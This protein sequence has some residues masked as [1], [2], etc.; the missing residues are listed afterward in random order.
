M[1]DNNKKTIIL[2]V[3]YTSILLASMIGATFAYFTS[4]V[5]GA[6]SKVELKSSVLSDAYAN[7][8]SVNL[9]VSLIDMQKN[10]SSNDY[11]SY[12]DSQQPGTLTLNSTVGDKLPKVTCTYDILY[13]PTTVYHSSIENNSNLKEFVINGY[14]EVTNGGSNVSFVGSM[15]ETD[16]TNVSDT[17]ILVHNAKLIIN[18][19]NNSGEITWNFIPRF[20]NLNIS[21]DDNANITFGGNISIGSLLCLNE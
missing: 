17:L 16:L 18:G 8:T 4:S 13:T 12:K 2:I 11:K 3:V 20:Y 21:Q 6:T 14:Q 1:K 9:D 5:S 15:E 10:N 19:V 7:G